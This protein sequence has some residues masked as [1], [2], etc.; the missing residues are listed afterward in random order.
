MSQN[1]K[2]LGGKIVKNTAAAGVG[3]PSFMFISRSLEEKPNLVLKTQ[4]PLNKNASLALVSRVAKL[5]VPAIRNIGNK[6]KD[7]G[8]S[9]IGTNFR[10]KPAA[11]ASIG[12][13]FA[14]LG[15][16]STN[17]QTQSREITR[18]LNRITT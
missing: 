14:A 18:G 11:A 1:L 17:L 2:S 7:V 12:T 4:E 8:G 5:S 9:F 13:S 10:S 15:N 16:T 6:V 3:Y